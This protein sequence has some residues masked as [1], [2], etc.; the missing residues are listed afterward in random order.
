MYIT[1]VSVINACGN[2]AKSQD[3]KNGNGEKTDNH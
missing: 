3:V 2:T 1:T